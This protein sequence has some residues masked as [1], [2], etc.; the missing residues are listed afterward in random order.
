MSSLLQGKAWSDFKRWCQPR[1]LSPLPAHPW[2]LAAYARW[3]EPKYKFAEIDK[4]FKSIARQHLLAGLAVPNRHPTVKKTL[5]LIEVR[6]AN[7]V[8]SSALF[9]A[10]D[11]LKTPPS[12]ALA[13]APETVEPERSESRT[14]SK[15]GYISMR[16]APRLVRRRSGLK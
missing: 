15:K 13:P 8:H 2:T 5:A 7:R 12:Q 3:C 6:C 9:D 10:D 14:K 1:G 16:S 4:N 11:F